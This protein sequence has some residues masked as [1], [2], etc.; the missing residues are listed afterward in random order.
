MVSFIITR[1]VFKKPNYQNISL[2]LVLKMSNNENFVGSA[3]NIKFLEV[4]SNFV[5]IKLLE[6]R[7]H[8]L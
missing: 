3:A 8:F 6:V 7:E 2:F 1:L 4:I 5:D